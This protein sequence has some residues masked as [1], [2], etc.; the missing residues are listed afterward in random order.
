MA[1]RLNFCFSVYIVILVNMYNI[2]SCKVFIALLLYFFLSWQ[3]SYE[4]MHRCLIFQDKTLK[5]YA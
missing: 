2:F 5:I 4:E 3:M 1:G